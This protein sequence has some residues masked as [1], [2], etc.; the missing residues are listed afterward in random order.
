MGEKWC[1]VFGDLK[2]L[3]GVSRDMGYT[4][5]VATYYFRCDAICERQ[6]NAC[7][8]WEDAHSAGTML[9]KRV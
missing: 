4:R 2:A 5:G 1:D 8:W 3:S 9:P 7:S 6:E